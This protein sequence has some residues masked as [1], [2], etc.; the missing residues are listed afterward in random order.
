MRIQGSIIFQKKVQAGVTLSAFFCRHT[1]L[2]FPETTFVGAGT[3]P[4][5]SR[6]SGEAAS[7]YLEKFPL[8]I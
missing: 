1:F 7:F 6:A 8:E 4:N 2:V 5:P 3:C